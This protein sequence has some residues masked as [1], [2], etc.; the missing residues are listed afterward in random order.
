MLWWAPLN[1][2]H[3]LHCWTL[4]RDNFQ[5]EEFTGQRDWIFLRLTEHTVKLPSVK[6]VPTYTFISDWREA[7]VHCTLQQQTTGFSLSLLISEI[8]IRLHF[9]L[10]FITSGGKYLKILFDYPYFFFCQM[11]VPILS[12]FF[13]SFWESFFWVLNISGLHTLLILP[14][15]FHYCL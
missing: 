3:C 11:S 13:L 6:T 12:A 7:Q 1:I 15:A 14:I 5:K 9:Y 4:S 2:N 8:K 10:D